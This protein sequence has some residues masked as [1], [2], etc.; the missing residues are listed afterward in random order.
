MTPDECGATSPAGCRT[1]RKGRLVARGRDYLLV[2]GVRTLSITKTVAF[3]VGMLPQ[4]TFA[5]LTVMFSPLPSILTGPPAVLSES[6]EP[7]A[8]RPLAS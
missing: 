3:L 2:P 7:A 5:P 4:R 6:T 1:T 8:D